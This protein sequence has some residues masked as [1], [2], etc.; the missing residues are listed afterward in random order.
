MLYAGRSPSGNEGDNIYN[1][2]HVPIPGGVPCVHVASGST[3]SSY[4]AISEDGKLFAWGRNEKGQLGLGHQSQVT[5]PTEVVGVPAV[6]QVASSRLHTVLVTQAGD[7]YSTGACNLGQLGLGKNVDFVSKFTKTAGG[8]AGSARKV[9][10]GID[11]TM[12]LDKDG[13]VWCCGSPQ[14]GQL[15]NGSTGEYIVSAG[16]MGYRDVPTLT[17]VANIAKVAGGKKVTDISCGANH[18]A[19]LLEDGRVLTWGCGGYGRCGHGNPQDVLVPTSIKLFEHERMRAKSLVCGGTIT[20]FVLHAGGLIY[21]CG[22]AK[23]SGEANMIPKALNDL[24]GWDVR[25]IACGSTS[26][27]VAAEQTLV[28]FGPSPTCGELGFGEVTKSSTKCK[29]VEDLGETHVIQVAAGHSSSLVL[30]DTVSETPLAKHAR[31][32]LE[33]GKIA[34]MKPAAPDASS[35]AAAEAAPAGGKG[36]KAGAAA[37]ATAGKKRAAPGGAS[38]A[39]ASGAGSASKKAKK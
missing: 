24:H 11:F 32:L 39:A 19:A 27:L 2:Q 30:L 3:S 17:V 21:F 1:F 4:F 5:L 25:S 7:V 18:T 12:V 20:Y 23:K 8:P 16:K 26:T 22:I 15:G 33:S 36:G 35:S 31:T 28:A 34:V 13:V 6:S 29:I 37:A 9:A 10:V 38:A 14:Y